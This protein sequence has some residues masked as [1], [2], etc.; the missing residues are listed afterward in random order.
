MTSQPAGIARTPPR[1][2][3]VLTGAGDRFLA[4]HLA[5]REDGLPPDAA[6]RAAVD[7][8]V[9]HISAEVP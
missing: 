7:A 9:A 8:S 3:V 2:G 4:A 6:L 5:A 1:D